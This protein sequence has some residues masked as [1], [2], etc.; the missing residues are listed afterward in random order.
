MRL[1]TCLPRDE[2]AIVNGE[3]SIDKALEAISK[4][5]IKGCLYN[6]VTDESLWEKTSISFSKSLKNAGITLLEY[7]PSFFIQPLE[8]EGCKPFAN[9]IVKA[10][11]ISESIG[12]LN[13]TVCTG[14]YNGV[15]SHP[16]NKTQESWELLKETC[17]LVAEEAARRNLRTRLLIEPVYTS[18]IW[19]PEILAK[20]IDEIDSPNIQGHM[21]IANCLNFDMI[22]DHGGFIKESFGILG[23]RIHSSHIKDVSPLSSS[24]FPGLEEKQTGEGVMDIRTY[25]DC[26][27]RMPAGF[28]AIIEHLHYMSDIRRSYTRIK[29]IADEMGISVWDE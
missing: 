9:S 19:S 17:V 27:S 24:Y 25:I 10:L 26:I 28:P 11:S 22:Y 1:G 5:G 7:N 3:F 21:D 16:R 8:H 2:S 4:E 23:S 6:F 14:G 18:V 12:C 13:A 29:A 15:Y 20:F